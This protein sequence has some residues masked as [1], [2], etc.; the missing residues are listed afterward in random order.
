M[1]Y[2]KGPW[3][4]FPHPTNWNE[5]N[6]VSE[7]RTKIGDRIEIASIYDST[8]VSTE[9]NVGNATLIAAAPTMHL[10]LETLVERL[11][12]DDMSNHGKDQAEALYAAASFLKT[13]KGEK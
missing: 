5:V 13:L 9:E 10:L 3:L 1:K 12:V 8:V 6:V 4:I 11:L 7:H 2:T